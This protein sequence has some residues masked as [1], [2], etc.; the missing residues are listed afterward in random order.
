MLAAAKP[1]AAAQRQRAAGRPGTLRQS[2]ARLASARRASAKPTQ[3][4][5]ILLAEKKKRFPA[6]MKTGSQGKKRPCSARTHFPTSAESACRHR[7]R[8]GAARRPRTFSAKG[9]M[10]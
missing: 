10:L 3:P 2:K 7:V 1:S 8:N 9:E 6:A 5:G 4:G